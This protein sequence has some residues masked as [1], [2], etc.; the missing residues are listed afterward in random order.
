[1]TSP[2]ESG[3]GVVGSEGL[4]S[5]SGCGSGSGSGSGLGVGSG[6]K[7]VQVSSVQKGYSPDCVHSVDSTR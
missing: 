1:M 6:R 3:S 5:G 7:S 4:C 2:P